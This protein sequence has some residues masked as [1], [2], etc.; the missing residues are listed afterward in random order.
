MEQVCPGPAIKDISSAGSDSTLG[1]GCVFGVAVYWH[2]VSVHGALPSGNKR[3]Q[4]QSI[5]GSRQWLLK[6]VLFSL[7]IS[8]IFLEHC[9]FAIPGLHWDA[10]MTKQ[11]SPLSR[12][13]HRPAGKAQ[14]C[15]KKHVTLCQGRTKVSGVSHAV[16]QS[17][18]PSAP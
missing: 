12:G 4:F 11:T 9:L 6:P 14:L 5:L 1:A 13:M 15:G 7:P 16:T 2:P 3:T 8:T 18:V 17:T 10:L